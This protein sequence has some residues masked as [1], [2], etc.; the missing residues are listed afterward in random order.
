MSAPGCFAGPPPSAACA[1]DG[2]AFP[3]KLLLCRLHLLLCDNGGPAPSTV[4]NGGA[5]WRA[6][7]PSACLV[8]STVKH[9]PEELQSR[10]AQVKG[11]VLGIAPAACSLGRTVPSWPR[12]KAVKRCCPGPGSLAV[13]LGHS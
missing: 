7:A 8:P 5:C 1:V 12:E 3:L 9:L 2:F 10:L 6:A 4:R 13:G 11:P